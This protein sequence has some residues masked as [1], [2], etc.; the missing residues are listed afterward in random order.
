[1]S[2]IAALSG[3]RAEIISN[4]SIAAFFRCVCGK[5]LAPIMTG[6][7]V[8]T[9]LAEDRREA[10]GILNSGQYR[11]GA[12]LL[13]CASADEGFAPIKFGTWAPV[14]FASSGPL[15]ATL[16]SRSIVINLAGC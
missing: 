13:R 16:E 6:D 14:A 3:P 7:E 12:H 15:P 9:F 1:M 11:A 8:E 5:S 10:I 4:L 2:I